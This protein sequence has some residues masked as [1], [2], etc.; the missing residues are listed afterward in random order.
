[1]PQAVGTG[2]RTTWCR[3]PAAAEASAAMK[4]VASTMAAPTANIAFWDMS[5]P[6][7]GFPSTSA[8]RFQ[9]Y[10][11]RRSEQARSPIKRSHAKLPMPLTLISDQTLRPLNTEPIAAIPHCINGPIVPAAP[12]SPHSGAG[13]FVSEEARVSL[14]TRHPTRRF[15]SACVSRTRRQRETMRFLRFLAS[16]NELADESITRPCSAP[17]RFGEPGLFVCAGNV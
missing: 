11:A 12:V 2:C 5:A 6:C 9:Q 7:V 14:G 4:Q 10:D 17:V 3:C 16:A 8:C 15:H 13:V 1:L